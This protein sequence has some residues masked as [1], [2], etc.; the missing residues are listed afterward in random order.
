VVRAF[1]G[2]LG[3]PADQIPGGLEAPVV[4]YRSRMA[5]R[6]MLVVLD[7]AR[8]AEQVRPLLPTGPSGL[9]VVTSRD[10]LVGLVAGHS[11]EPLALGRPT[12]AEAREMLAGR[13][14]YDQA[15]A[16]DDVIAACARLPLALAV[17]AA[18]AVTDRGA[19][20]TAL[21][22]RLRDQPLDVLAAGDPRTDVRAVLSWSYTIL[23]PSAAR[24]F[25]LLA[26][27]PWGEVSTDAAASLAG[28]SRAGIGAPLSALV[29]TRL[30]DEPFPGRYTMH[31]L[32]R[33]YAAELAD[34]RD[35]PE[36]RR[37]ARTRLLGHYLHTAQAA[38]TFLAPG[39]APVVAPSPVPGVVSTPLAD[40][41]EARDW[42]VTERAG[43]AWATVHSRPLAQAVE[44]HLPRCASGGAAARRAA[45]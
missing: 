18:R 27:V 23:E 19:S 17:T 21:A 5:G 2:A 14:G 13:L 40:R 3:E 29:R 44:R 4:L 37:A 36:E 7:N 28:V 38:L 20:L 34:D 6:R 12:T 1:L 26:L 9:T 30:V 43:L 41:H 10:P 11:A 24:L 35:D 33:A 42:L 22:G 39:C 45:A 15:A 31:D 16:F 25:R 8:D 32:L